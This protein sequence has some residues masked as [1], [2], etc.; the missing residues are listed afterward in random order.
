MLVAALGA[1]AAGCSSAR[2]CTTEARPGLVIHVRDRGTGQAIC[3]A[4]VVIVDGDYRETLPKNAPDCTYYGAY[5]RSGTYGIE[6]R[7]TASS[8]PKSIDGVAVSGD[9]TGCHVEKT[10]LTVDLDPP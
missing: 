1:P 5:E 3:D 6:I 2:T 4:D 10:E 7:R 8:A 9:D